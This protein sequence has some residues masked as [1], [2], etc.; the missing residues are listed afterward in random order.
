MAATPPPAF[1]VGVGFTVMVL[2]ANIVPHE[3]PAVV[4]VNVTV[5]GAVA[6]PV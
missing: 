3:P 6:E 1:T 5:A 4:S 2:V